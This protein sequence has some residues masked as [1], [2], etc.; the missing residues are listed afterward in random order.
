MKLAP[1]ALFAYNR[2]DHLSRTLRAL[3]DC[4]LASDSELYLFVDGPRQDADRSNVEQVLAVARAITGFKRVQVQERQENH[5]LARSVIAGVTAVSKSH[6]RVI[7]LEDDLVV[8]RGFL[9]FMNEALRRFDDE[10]R[11]MQ[12]SGYMFP[13][14]DASAVGS[15]M[16]SRVPASWGWGTWDRA[17]RHFERDSG[18]L[19]ALLRDERTQND[20]DLQGAYPYYAQLQL[21]ASGQLDVWGVRWYASMFAR[22]GLCL[23]PAQSLVQNIGMDGSGLHCGTSQAF[24]VSLSRH[25]AWQFPDQIEESQEALAQIREFLWQRGTANNERQA[26]SA[27]EGTWSTVGLLKR[28]A[29]ARFK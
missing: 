15:T 24:D 26:Q 10:P 18:R 2:P 11:V 17:W 8:A 5:G 4:P 1:I 6:G 27:R 12:V 7:V 16:L 3:R 14:A 9:L 19:L 13:I 23:Y 25:E 29:K 28:L 21:Q 22:N 20:F